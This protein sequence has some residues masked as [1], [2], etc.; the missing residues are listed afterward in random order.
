MIPFTWNMES[1]KSEASRCDR[2]IGTL[3]WVTLLWLKAL[4]H[5]A[6]PSR[7]SRASVVWRGYP[8]RCQLS[9]RDVSPITMMWSWRSAESARLRASNEKWREVAA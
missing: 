6:S 3:L 5:D 8:S 2:S 4:R 1:R 7:V 9:A